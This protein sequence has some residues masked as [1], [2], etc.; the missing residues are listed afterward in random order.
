MVSRPR[1]TTRGSREGEEI[2]QRCGKYA[3]FEN[4]PRERLSPGLLHHSAA[5]LARHHRR[6]AS[7]ISRRLP[8]RCQFRLHGPRDRDFLAE[9]S[10]RKCPLISPSNPLVLTC[11]QRRLAR[12]LFSSYDAARDFGRSN[13]NDMWNR[14]PAPPRRN[15]RDDSGDGRGEHQQ[16]ARQDV[17]DDVTRRG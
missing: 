5:L 7:Q 6:A 1:A 11:S 16:S 14:S 2:A 8:L 17:P 12:D 15:Q 13:K 9:D 10:A 3:M 4:G